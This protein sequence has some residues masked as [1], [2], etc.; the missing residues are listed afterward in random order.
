MFPRLSLAVSI[1]FD[2]HLSL[3]LFCFMHCIWPL[4]FCTLCAVAAMHEDALFPKNVNYLLSGSN[5]FTI[6]KNYKK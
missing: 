4:L 1:N 3:I 2:N 6:Q 5:A